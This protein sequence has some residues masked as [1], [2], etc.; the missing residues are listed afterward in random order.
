MKEEYKAYRVSIL[1]GIIA[2]VLTF[3]LTILIGGLFTHIFYFI[4]IL[5]LSVIILSSE[6]F[7]KM[8]EEY[9]PYCVSILVGIIA[10]VV[11][12]FLLYSVITLMA[13]SKHIFMLLVGIV[14]STSVILLSSILSGKFSI[15]WKRIRARFYC[16]ILLLLIYTYFSM[17]FFGYSFSELLLAPFYFVIILPFFI[18]MVPVGFLCSNVLTIPAAYVAT[19]EIENLPLRIISAFLLAILICLAVL[20]PIISTMGY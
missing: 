16:I 9:K 10:S 18:K 4:V 3:F 5:T 6:L 14:P 2:C 11:G 20:L 12:G 17:F 8:K 7:K 13:L 19:R 15:T 1:V